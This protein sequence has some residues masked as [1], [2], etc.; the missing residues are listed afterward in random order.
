MSA[1]IVTKEPLADDVSDDD[2]QRM[3]SLRLKA[4]CVRCW[5][6]TESGKRVLCTEWN[7]IGEND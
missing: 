1:T 6:V 3:I 5:V 4:G 2:I 7:V